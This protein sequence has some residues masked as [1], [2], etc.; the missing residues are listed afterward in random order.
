M[1]DDLIQAALKNGIWT[2]MF[3]MLFIW[4]LKQNDR[5]EQ[6]LIN[7][8]DT[9]ATALKKVDEIKTCVDEMRKDVA[10]SSRRQ[11]SMIGR[12]LDKMSATKGE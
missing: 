10:E 12:V 11:E 4:V 8:V 5:R 6:R 2:A 9:Q 3:V 7:V 1:W